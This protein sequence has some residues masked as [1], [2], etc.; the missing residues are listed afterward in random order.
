MYATKISM[1]C[2]PPCA[3]CSVGIWSA[4]PSLREHVLDQVLAE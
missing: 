4:S 1:I 3:R 2:S